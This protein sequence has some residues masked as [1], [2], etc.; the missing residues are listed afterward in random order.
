MLVKYTVHFA[1]ARG[2]IFTEKLARLDALSDKSKDDN[3]NLLLYDVLQSD[4]SSLIRE[5]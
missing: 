3:R 5:L 2:E 4:S 1:R